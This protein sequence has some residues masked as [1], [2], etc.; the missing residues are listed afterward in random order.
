MATGQ[1]RAIVR[2]FVY[3]IQ[4]RLDCLN[5][6]VLNYH[7]HEC[8][9]LRPKNSS[10]HIIMVFLGKCHS[11]VT[12]PWTVSVNTFSCFLLLLFYSSCTFWYRMESN[13][14]SCCRSVGDIEI[15]IVG[16]CVGG[17]C[18]EMQTNSWKYKLP[19]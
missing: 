3:L 13:W 19:F 5:V 15:Y 9:K 1:K 16:E 17:R 2:K 7:S 12:N 6:N 11:I 4:C 10:I 14:D 8:L 18:N